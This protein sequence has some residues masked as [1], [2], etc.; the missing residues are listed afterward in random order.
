MSSLSL[1]H[2]E[3]CTNQTFL[4]GADRLRDTMATP[5]MT[6]TSLSILLSA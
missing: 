1:N 2:V 6:S 5:E 3:F 4:P